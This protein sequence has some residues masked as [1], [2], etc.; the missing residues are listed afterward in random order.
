M[1]NVNKVDIIIKLERI[2]FAFALGTFVINPFL[3]TS[4]NLAWKV[5]MKKKIVANGVSD[6]R[7]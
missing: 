3:L 4:I 5:F 7:L 2:C 6:I 1:R